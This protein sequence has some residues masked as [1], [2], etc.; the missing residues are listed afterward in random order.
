MLEELAEL[1]LGTRE[2]RFYL[3]VLALGRCT[4]AQAASHSG[5]SRTSGYDLAKRL[6]ERG[7]LRTIDFGV[8]GHH[9]DGRMSELVAA[10]PTQLLTE[11]DRRRQIVDSLIPQLRAIQMSAKARPKVRHL[12][13]VNGIREAL[14]ETL[15][16]PSPLRG[17]FSMKDLF[18]VP[19][20]D[21]LDEY[22]RARQE[23][24]LT[25]HVVRSIERDIPARWQSSETEFR[26]ARHA[27]A[28]SVF[29]MTTI[30]GESSVAI[31]SSR[32]E[33]FAMM[34]DSNEYAQTQ[35]NLFD[36]LWGV[37]VPI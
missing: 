34:I 18:A 11:A 9:R 21:T 22:V 16:W 25:L 31:V 17:I 7:L 23:R 15:E 20:E 5:T 27:P 26:V 33:A 14:M 10:D 36:V 2:A 37:S 32:R 35:A 29:T 3:A 30:I 8:E 12:E 4:V 1:G 28:G 19:G 6:V 24:S 13:G